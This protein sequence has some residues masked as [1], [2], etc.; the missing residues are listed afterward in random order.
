M[1]NHVGKS[2]AGG[3]RPIS[4]VALIRLNLRVVVRVSGLHLRLPGIASPNIGL[5]SFAW[6][7]HIR[8]MV[9]GRL[10]LVIVLM[11]I[12]G[13]WVV[14]MIHGAN[15]SITRLFHIGI[16]RHFGRRSGSFLGILIW[17]LE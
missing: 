13:L 10:L 1:S 5:P 7:H 17:S 12:D 2:I 6:M 14:E 16:E 15:I 4:K 11:G 8:M 3:L 9:G